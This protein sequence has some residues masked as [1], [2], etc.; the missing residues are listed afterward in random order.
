MSQCCSTTEDEV[1]YSVIVL[2]SLGFVELLETHGPAAHRTLKLVTVA[3]V[4]SHAIDVLDWYPW[5]S[6]VQSSRLLI[7]RDGRLGE[8]SLRLVL[9]ARPT[10]DPGWCVRCHIAK[11][12]WILLCVEVTHLDDGRQMVFVER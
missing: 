10:L 9:V 2:L 4:T 7:L 11:L 12:R 8:Q 3:G 6:C 1:A 5:V